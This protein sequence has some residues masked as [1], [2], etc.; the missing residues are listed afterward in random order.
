[1]FAENFIENRKHFV[2]AGDFNVLDHQNDVQDFKN[3]E[4]DALGNLS[5]KVI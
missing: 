4:N 2:I 1:M 3:W 5:S